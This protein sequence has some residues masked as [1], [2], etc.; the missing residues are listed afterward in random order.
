MVVIV[1]ELAVV[2]LEVFVAVLVLE[3]VLSVVVVVVVH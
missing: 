3:T 2:L 1:G